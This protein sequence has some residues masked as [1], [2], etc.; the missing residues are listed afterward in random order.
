MGSVF[1]FWFVCF[2]QLCTEVQPS[3]VRIYR[4]GSNSKATVILDQPR[5]ASE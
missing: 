2:R 1:A 4:V 5:Y 3:C